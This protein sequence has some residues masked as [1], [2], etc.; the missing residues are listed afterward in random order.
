[1]I[2][3]P[4]ESPKT[5]MA[6]EQ[7]KEETKGISMWL[8]RLTL[9]PVLCVTQ[10]GCTDTPAGKAVSADDA[11]PQ[12]SRGGP[13]NGHPWVVYPDVLAKWVREI[14]EIA[15]GTPADEVIKRLGEPDQD[16][17]NAP[18]TFDPFASD[19]GY[20]RYVVYFVA[21]DDAFKG[22][23]VNS[24][25][26]LVDIE[27]IALVFGPDNRYKTYWVDNPLHP[28]SVNTLSTPINPDQIF[29]HDLTSLVLAGPAASTRPIVSQP[30]P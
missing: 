20:D 8:L 15:K 4:I 24:A 22:A 5:S 10:L 6:K 25:S 19:A 18:E 28:F 9:L 27:S 1:M 23:P 17:I 13:R 30:A 7:A 11:K 3:V 12:L 2:V 29:D 21:M 26:Y 16:Y 14:P